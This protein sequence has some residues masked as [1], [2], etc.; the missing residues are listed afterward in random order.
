M[1]QIRKHAADLVVTHYGRVDANSAVR[2]YKDFLLLLLESNAPAHLPVFTTNYDTAVEDFVDAAGEGFRL[3]DGFSTGSRR[4]WSPDTMLHLY[5]AGS[6]DSGTKSILL[7]KLHGSS[8]W[9]L[10]TQTQ[11]FTKESTAEPAGETSGYENALVWPGLTKVLKKGPY[12]TNYA[13]LEEC[14]RHAR[15]CVVIGFSFRDQVIR[16][17]FT[18]ALTANQD[19]QIAVIDPGA[20]AVIRDRLEAEDFT[21][22]KP[23]AA[24]FGMEKLAQIGLDL[25]K[26]HFPWKPGH[27]VGLTAQPD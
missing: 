1:R 17:Y 24:R 16:K 27:L 22:V 15:L 18:L 6:A 7:L 21:R 14:L 4:I 19:L 26:L 8:T 5:R 3:I 12:E 9:R 10:N 11:E 2:L 23:I 13:Y 20:E 25:A